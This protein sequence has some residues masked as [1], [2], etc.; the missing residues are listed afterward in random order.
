MQDSEIRF[1]IQFSIPEG[2]TPAVKEILAKLIK[3]ARDE[4][5]MLLYE[6]FF[7]DDVSEVYGHEWYAEATAVAAHMEA[8]GE[9]LAKLHESTSVKRVD[10][11]GNVPDDLREEI[12]PFNPNIARHWDGFTR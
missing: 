8:G 1:M 7:N 11:F 9:T 5:G 6:W 10:V 4:Q 2:K 12:K 3:I